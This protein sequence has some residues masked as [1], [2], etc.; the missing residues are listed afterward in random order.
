MQNSLRYKLVLHNSR[1]TRVNSHANTVKAKHIS[2]CRQHLWQRINQPFIHLGSLHTLSVRNTMLRELRHSSEAIVSLPW[3]I[4]QARF[5]LYVCL[6]SQ[7]Y[8]Y[9]KWSGKER[10]DTIRSTHNSVEL[11][12]TAWMG[13]EGGESLTHDIRMNVYRIFC[14]VSFINPTREKIWGW[15]L[16]MHFFLFTCPPLAFLP[17]ATQREGYVS[18]NDRT[19]LVSKPS[20]HTYKH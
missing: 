20:P 10:A 7:Q 1:P 16:Q 8:S 4:H 5:D 15:N 17:K 19:S 3:W 6:W 2:C 11:W 12:E 9:S 18:N 14:S 13:V